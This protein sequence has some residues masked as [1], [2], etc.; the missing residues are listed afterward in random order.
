[1]AQAGGDPISR[2]KRAP[3]AAANPDAPLDRYVSRVLE[4]IGQVSLAPPAQFALHAIP[5]GEA[6]GR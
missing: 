2:R 6:C 5:V 1:M 3:T 4:V